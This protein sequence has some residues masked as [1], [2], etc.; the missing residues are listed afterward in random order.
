MCDIS[1][2]LLLIRAIDIEHDNDDDEVQWFGGLGK[3]VGAG[4]SKHLLPA[5]ND[6]FGGDD[7]AIEDDEATLRVPGLAR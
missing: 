5:N 3:A 7:D 2:D 6:I 4:A 1:S